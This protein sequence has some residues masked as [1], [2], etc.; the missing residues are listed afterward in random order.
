VYDFLIDKMMGMDSTESKR[1]KIR[2]YKD[3]RI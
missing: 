2:V 1:N 3:V